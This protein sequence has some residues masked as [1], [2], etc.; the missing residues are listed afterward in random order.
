MYLRHEP[1]TFSFELLQV[2]CIGGELRSWTGTHNFL[3]AQAAMHT[4]P[5]DRPVEVRLERKHTP[6]SFVCG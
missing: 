6:A 2:G 4:A 3:R 1:L 5:S